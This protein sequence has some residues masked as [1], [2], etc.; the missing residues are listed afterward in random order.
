MESRK[1]YLTTRLNKCDYRSGSRCRYY[2]GRDEGQKP[3]GSSRCFPGVICRGTHRNRVSIVMHFRVWGAERRRETR[4]LFFCA[5]EV[6][7]RS[8]VPLLS[9]KYCLSSLGTIYIFTAFPFE[10]S[11]LVRRF[12][13]LACPKTAFASVLEGV[14]WVDMRWRCHFTHLSQQKPKEM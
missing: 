5:L 8:Q 6:F 11:P 3:T 1:S 10:S 14:E 4:F 9:F 7:R 13:L 12:M 2:Q